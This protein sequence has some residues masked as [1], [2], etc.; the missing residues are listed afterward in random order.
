MLF[1]DDRQANIFNVS[2]SAQ[3]LSTVGNWDLFTITASSGSRVQILDI[4]LGQQSTAPSAIQALGIQC[5]SGSTAGSGGTAITP[6][7]TKRWTAAPA[8]V[9]NVLGPSTAL[10][11]TASAT[12]I[13]ANAFEAASGRFR[14][15]STEDYGIP[16]VISN[17]QRFVMRVTTPQ[18]A[19]KISATLTFKELGYGL[20]A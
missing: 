10:A 9:T 5:F 4:D 17:S 16:I 2:F 12:Q 8:T 3:T 1:N 14:Y 11:S 15:R 18:T 13:Y 6:V 19:V 20:P 7:N